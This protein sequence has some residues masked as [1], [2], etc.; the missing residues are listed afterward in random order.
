MGTR[1]ESGQPVVSDHPAAN[2]PVINGA[3][4]A[5]NTTQVD[6]GVYQIRLHLWLNDGTETFDAATGIRI[7]N[8][9][10]TA[11]P[12]LTPTPRPNRSPV[13]S[14]IPSQEVNAGR[15]I[16]ST[17]VAS[18]PDGDA[19]NLFVASSNNAIAVHP[20]DQQDGDQC[21]GA[22]GGRCHRSP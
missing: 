18:D 9:A 10:P 14:P 20:G 5:V 16:S 1:S 3:L 7:S 15:V 12:T 8:S 4:G 13:I 17:V 22:Y 21:D 11:V 19:V 2:P 6:D